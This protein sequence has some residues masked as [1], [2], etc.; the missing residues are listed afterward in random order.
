MSDPNKKGPQGWKQRPGQAP[1]PPLRRDPSPMRYPPVQQRFQPISPHPIHRQS[2]TPWASELQNFGNVV[3]PGSKAFSPVPQNEGASATPYAPAKARVFSPGPPPTTSRMFSPIPQGQNPNARHF[4]PAPQMNPRH[5]SPVPTMSTARHLSATPPISQ[6]PRQKSPTP[7]FDAR[8]QLR[9]LS[10]TPTGFNT[11]YDSRQQQSQ[12]SSYQ[13]PPL[14]FKPVQ[15]PSPAT[16]SYADTSYPRPYRQAFSP[17]PQM[18]NQPIQAPPTPSSIPPFSPPPTI[19][20][21]SYAQEY[22]GGKSTTDF[23]VVPLEPASLSRNLNIYNQEE[24]RPSTADII[25]QQSQDYVDE[26]LAEY[27]GVI[28]YLQGMVIE[29]C[30]FYVTITGLLV[31]SG[32][33]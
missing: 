30:I 18:Q 13:P 23:Y 19:M 25:A 14:T 15:P 21:P 10:N 6:Q 4:S 26:K 31:K 12:E 9:H 1:P 2:P 16:V 7:Q 24:N 28:S 8:Q 27:Q 22:P 11:I 20:L 5:F 32:A 33:F 29:L 3:G 17:A